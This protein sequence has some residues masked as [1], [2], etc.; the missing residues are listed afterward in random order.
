MRT[1]LAC[2]RQD[3]AERIAL[4]LA[5]A[6]PSAIL[7]RVSTA[8]SCR[9]ALGSSPPEL[10]VLQHDP[11]ALD[12]LQLLEELYRPSDV[13]T[14]VAI[15]DAD[16]ALAARCMER[17][18]A[19]V[20][21]PILETLP[22][23]LGLAVARARNLASYRRTETALRASEASYRQLF[24]AN[25]HPMWIYD[26]ETLR[27]LA[28]NDAA[29]AHYGYSEAE[30]LGMTIKDIRPAE[31]VPALIANV[32]SV[33][34]GLDEA[35]IWRHRKK[36]G[37]LI[38]VEITSHT[39]EFGG[40][41][42]EAVLANDV[43]RRRQA[44]RRVER[45]SR[46]YAALSQTNQAIT[47][48][49]TREQLFE[50]VCRIA[51]HEG[52][53]RLAWIGIVGQG[54]RVSPV[55]ACGDSLG[56]LGEL[57]ISTDERVPEGRGPT[58]MAIRTGTHQIVADVGGDPRMGPWREAARGAH[59]R[60]SAAFPLRQRGRVVGALNLYASETNLFDADMVGLLDEMAADISF[61]LDSFE[62]EALR[63]RAEAER[64][65]S[66]TLA[67]VGT[68]VAGVAQ[69]VRT[70]VFGLT[71]AVDT[72]EARFRDEPAL[73]PYLKILREQSARLAELMNELLDYATPRRQELDPGHI[74]PVVNRAIDACQPLAASLHVALEPAVPGGIPPL[75]LDADRLASALQNVIENA[76]QHSPKGGRV[77]MR[78]AKLEWA[79]EDWVEV[80]IDDSGPGFR[81][82]DL[83]AVFEPFFSRRR[84]ATGLGLTLAARIVE[85][86][87]G[88]IEATNR[89]EGGG[90]V[91]IT[92]PSGLPQAGEAPDPEE[93]A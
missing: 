72:I 55:A 68:L 39:L 21:L 14:V 49:R 83:R 26:L 67:A 90:S 45:L 74:G 42:A 20:A 22:E 65:R 44:E 47:R 15:A 3:T 28:V 52:G 91:R 10:L 48:I 59:L 25:P 86:H 64:R 18:A 9:Q 32:A 29:V 50:E 27:F 81:R 12:A 31:D 84:G 73:A 33:T 43:T 13:A 19:V 88:S 1:L 34:A 77:R 92:L 38:E 30:F 24:L 66:E 4:A 75:R 7:D 5:G 93:V 85:E 35:G 79:G 58:G 61:A 23:V 69:E 8:E 6:T 36:D 70:P 62:A 87:G 76:I 89:P 57:R 80:V 46:L 71:A 78:A 17:G 2:A 82:D 16:P 41:R 54:S 37:S 11:P 40:R 63:V 53:L 51:V 56:Y 60:S